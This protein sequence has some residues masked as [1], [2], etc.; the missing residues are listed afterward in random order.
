M[1]IQSNFQWI[2]KGGCYSGNKKS[3]T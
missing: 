2:A 3:G 1:K